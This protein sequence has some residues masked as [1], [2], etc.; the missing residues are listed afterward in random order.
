MQKKQREKAFFA[1]QR[2][3][4]AA[5]KA[6]ADQLSATRIAAM[7]DDERAAHERAERERTAHATAVHRQAKKGYKSFKPKGL[8]GKIG[9]RKKKKRALRTPSPSVSEEE[10]DEEEDGGDVV[11][12]LATA[13]LTA[14]G[15][16]QPPAAAPFLQRGGTSLANAGVVHGVNEGNLDAR[17]RRT[18]LTMKSLA[19]DTQISVTVPGECTCF[20]FVYD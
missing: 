13:P 6:A 18:I 9:G 4:K 5:A 20:C 7:N 8:R 14:A 2:K 12:P 11:M 15:L 17:R 16:A 10:D 3:E 1:A 19:K